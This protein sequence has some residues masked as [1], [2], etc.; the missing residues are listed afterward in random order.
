MHSSSKFNYIDKKDFIR[1]VLNNLPNF[2]TFCVLH[3]NE[4]N[5]PLL[6]D[7]Y[8]FIIGIGAQKQFNS[9]NPHD[10]DFFNS[11]EQE[12][13]FLM[14]FISYSY[15]KDFWKITEK[16]TTI[17]PPAN[18]FWFVPE[19]LIYKKREDKEFIVFGE[20]PLEFYHS[21]LQSDVQPICASSAFQHEFLPLLSKERYIQ[22]ID[23][24]RE[25]IKNGDYYEMNFCQEFISKNFDS[26]P[27]LI[28]EKVRNSN[29][30]PFSAFFRH[31]SFF[32][33]SL[34]PERFLK[35]KEGCILTQPIKGTAMRGRTAEEDEKNQSNLKKSEKERAENIMIVD[36]VRNDLSRVCKVGTVNV[37][38]LCG[39]YSFKN[40]HQMISSVS[41][42]LLKESSLGD[43]LKNTFPMGSMT[44]APKRMVVERA[45]E[46][47]ASA[48]GIYSGSIG[49]IEPN[50][51]FDLNVVIRTLIID[52]EK[53]IASF[54]VGGAITYDSDPIA[55]YEECML[56][57]K[58]WLDLF[59]SN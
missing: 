37:E 54:H 55:E 20:N 14:G 7:E 16:K 8:D 49:Y 28:W 11:I 30:A 53:K 4:I 1:L 57:G 26:D 27:F 22:T 56:K 15:N 29:R 23:K 46:Y 47:E 9:T 59:K 38:E 21:I 5:S 13:S 31:E 19:Y 18:S 32:T 33:I 2:S 52:T 34:S 6:Q 51:N 3:S 42:N 43:I 41:G 25:D 44:G 35:K 58:F 12:N 10:W 36:L 39:I 24:I 45:S 40:V 48:R 17:T 50:G